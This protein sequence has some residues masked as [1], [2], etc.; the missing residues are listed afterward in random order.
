VL[1]PII[2]ILM[3]VS[4]DPIIT[5]MSPQDTASQTL[6]QAVV[7]GRQARE[8]G[9]TGLGPLLKGG[10]T[11]SEQLGDSTFGAAIEAIV[12]AGRWRALTEPDLAFPWLESE[13]N[14]LLDDL[15]FEPVLEAD[16]PLGFPAPTPVREIELKQYPAYRSVSADLGGLGSGG[17]FWKLFTHI[18]SNDIAMTA[19]VEMSYATADDG[20]RET[21][22]AF[23]YG[24]PEIGTPGLDG[25]V[26]V[27]D[28]TSGWVVSIGCRGR[29]T[30]AKVSEA[31]AQLLAWIATRPE[32]KTDG[33]LRV[34]GYNSPMVRGE[35]R[36]FEVQLPV[37]RKATAVVDFSSE[38]EVTSWQVIND[39]VMGG[40]ST[41]M[42]WSTGDGTGLF[43]GNMSLENNGGFASVRS[44]SIQGRLEG[45][46]QV[47]LRLRGD[48]QSYKFRMYTDAAPRVAYQAP[49]ET[50]AGEWSEH[51][52]MAADFTPA[53]R[54]RA[55]SEMPAL[56][57]DRVFNL[58][59][60]ISDG[61]EGPFRLEL[62]TIERR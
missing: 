16:L 43:V 59:L 26:E 29:E 34:M 49:F 14:G 22:M 35:R 7:Q 52:F 33:A 30:D 5:D 38:R 15:E 40:R 48:G 17:A 19:P 18:T 41:S 44:G 42:I 60:I 58:G 1:N 24:D 3:T 8:A 51:N 56:D 37:L 23:L 62:G 55:L 2:A 12:E 21:K 6:R 27:K 9:S 25:V 53:W 20:L 45:A 39:S 32:L 61:Q 11:A 36:Y 54:G 46:K 4:A 13:L 10:I 50:T 28:A 57:F 47:T 31:Q